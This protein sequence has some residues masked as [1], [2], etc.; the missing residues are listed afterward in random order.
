MAGVMGIHRFYLNA[1]ENAALEGEKAK[2]VTTNGVLHVSNSELEGITLLRLSEAGNVF[3]PV[4][5]VPD[6]EE[7]TLHTEQLKKFMDV[8]KDDSNKRREQWKANLLR[9]VE[10]WRTNGTFTISDDTVFME[11]R[12]KL[13]DGGAAKQRG[14]I[15]V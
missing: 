15:Q 5:G 7:D 13:T 8:D 6:F 1:N 9:S 2:V 3:L 11:Y 10:E 12:H 14:T 4:E